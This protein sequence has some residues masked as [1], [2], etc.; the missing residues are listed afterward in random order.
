MPT[1]PRGSVA[2]AM[3][4]AG[5]HV[6]PALA[7]QKRPATRN[8]FKDATT[9]PRM[10][11][12]WWAANPHFNI[13]IAT[14]A[15]RLVVIDC[16]AGKPWP[17]DGQPPEGCRTGDH[18]LT[19]EGVA[20]GVIS[21]D[22]M[23]S[24]GVP[25]VATPSGGVH[26]YYRAPRRPEVRSRANV[27]PWVDVRG[28]GGYVVAPY[29]STP[30]GHYRPLHGWGSLV[31]GHA[32][33]DLQAVGAP[34]MVSIGLRLPVLPEW[35]LEILEPPEGDLPV[36]DQD[37]LDMIRRRL[38]VP[39]IGSGYAAAALAR[40]VELVRTASEGSRNQRLNRAAYSLGTLVGSGHLDEIEVVRHL[41]DAA[42]VAG[43]DSGEIRPTIS[44]GLR[45]GKA[46][47]REVVGL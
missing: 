14:E 22:W 37:V 4:R 17:G 15:S 11:A 36:R 1:I 26:L 9:N 42:M 5:L 21:S 29:S 8:G 44:S 43:L 35:L 47:P 28:M 18:I 39:S 27:L 13:C 41:E 31:H 19:R 12:A 2:L 33:A 40:E 34:E 23:Y 32:D 10:I 30:A 38:D 6:F 24:S 7:G 16:D 45:A 20:A 25:A 46:S 3:A